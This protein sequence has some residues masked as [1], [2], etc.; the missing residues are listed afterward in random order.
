MGRSGLGTD[1]LDVRTQ[2]QEPRE[3]A[4]AVVEAEGCASTVDDDDKL[5]SHK[6]N[7]RSRS[8]HW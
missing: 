1:P 6:E 5:L 7:F 2:G 4:G 8:P 3:E